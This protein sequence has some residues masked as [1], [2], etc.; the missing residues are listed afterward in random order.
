MAL[1]NILVLRR[2]S[3]LFCSSSLAFNV[4]R[5]SGLQ[6]QVGNKP[7]ERQRIGRIVASF[8]SPLCALCSIQRRETARVH[9]GSLSRVNR[10][11]ALAC[12]LLKSSVRDVD[13]VLCYSRDSLEN[14]RSGKMLKEK[15]GP[16]RI[17][18]VN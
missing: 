7:K 5:C 16:S 6:P 2:L 11:L 15:A 8:H 3:H 4:I 9:C 17:K 1:I 13:E 14:M 18:S 10:L 12:R